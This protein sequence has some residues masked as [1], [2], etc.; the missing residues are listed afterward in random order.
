WEFEVYDA[1]VTGID[2]D[3][4]QVPGTFSLDQNYPNP[5]NRSTVFAFDMP[6][7]GLA[8]LQLYNLQGKLIVTII[9]EVKPAG[10]HTIQWSDDHLVSGIYFYRFS[11]GEFSAV[12]K[13]ILLK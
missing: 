11:A 13:L 4:Q 2:E 5:F 8:E 1:F 6:K 9:S 3:P 10:R 7:T 12:R